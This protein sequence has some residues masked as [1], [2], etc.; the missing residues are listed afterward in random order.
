MEQRL[1]GKENEIEDLRAKIRRLSDSTEQ[2]NEVRIW[3]V[4]VYVLI[5][6][7]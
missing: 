7:F 4:C 5:V 2:D 1:E 3:S 6:M